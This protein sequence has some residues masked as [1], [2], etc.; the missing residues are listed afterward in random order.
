MPSPVEVV[1]RPCQAICPSTFRFSVCLVYADPRTSWCS[2]WAPMLH[3]RLISTE[4]STML[5]SVNL[6]MS[7]WHGNVK[8]SQRRTAL[9]CDMNPDT[10]VATSVT[11]ACALFLLTRPPGI[12]GAA[13]L[14]SPSETHA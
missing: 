5:H 7:L 1:V 9:L 14:F 8:A 2:S 12:L 10:N 3:H 4:A 13:L 11:R 6:E